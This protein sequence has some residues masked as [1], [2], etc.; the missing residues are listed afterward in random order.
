MLWLWSKRQDVGSSP[1]L[2]LE[3]A[4]NLCWFLL[5]EGNEEYIWQWFDTEVASLAG[6]KIRENFRWSLRL[7]GGLARAHCEWSEDGSP[8]PAILC[9]K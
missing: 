1:V 3:F 9:L 6:E 2:E 5:A 8:D 7:L 4:N